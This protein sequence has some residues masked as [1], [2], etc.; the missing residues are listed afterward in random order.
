MPFQQLREQLEEPP[1]RGRRDAR[2]L[3]A[4][5]DDAVEEGGEVGDDE[6]VRGR[7]GHVQRRPGL[8]FSD[9]VRLHVGI[10][11]F[12]SQTELKEQHILHNTAIYNHEM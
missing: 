10:F 6:A 11:H 3:R 2:V 1:R 7:V 5:K 9:V 4:V 8:I 12:K